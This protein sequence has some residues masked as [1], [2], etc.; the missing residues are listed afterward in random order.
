[1]LRDIRRNGRC[2]LDVLSRRVSDF[3]VSS[4][5]VVSEIVSKRSRGGLSCI[6]NNETCP[7]V[8]FDE[9]TGEEV[10]GHLG[11]HP[12]EPDEANALLPLRSRDN[13]LK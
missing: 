11:S 12:P 6:A 2:C 3:D 9:C 1:M 10:I 13:G 8:R 5:E 4:W 7:A